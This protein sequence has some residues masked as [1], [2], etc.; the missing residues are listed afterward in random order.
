[1]FTHVAISCNMTY[2]LSTAGCDTHFPILVLGLFQCCVGQHS[3]TLW[4][5]EHSI[6]FTDHMPE[7]PLTT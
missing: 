7:Q 1:M 6:L 5:Q 2:F 4:K 3:N